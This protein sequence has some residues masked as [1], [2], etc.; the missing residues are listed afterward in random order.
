ML[1]PGEGQFR[2]RFRPNRDDNHPTQSPYNLQPHG[3]QPS[4]AAENI[5]TPDDISEDNVS[6]N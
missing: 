6:L 1:P 5:A 2:P 4:H 3:Q